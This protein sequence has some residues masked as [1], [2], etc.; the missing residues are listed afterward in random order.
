MGKEASG[1]FLKRRTKKLLLRCRAFAEMPGL[2]KVTKQKFFAS[3]FQKRRPLFLFLLLVATPAHAA[4]HLSVVLDWFINPDHAPIL[5]AQQIGAYAAEGLDVDLIQ[6]ADAT[7]GPKLVAAGQADLVLTAEPQFIEQVDAGLNLV[8]VG[9][10]ID[11][12]LSTLVVLQGSG[13]HKLAD[14][15]GKTIGYGA[16]EAERV[17]VGVMLRQAGLSLSN[18]HLVQIGEQLSVA[19]LSRQVDA[20]SVY[21]NFEPLEI[22]RQGAGVVQFDY[23]RN[24]VPVF[25][26]LMLAARPIIRNDTRFARFLR[27]TTR[28]LAYLH[29]HPNE[30]W[31]MVRR[32]HPD[33]DD[34]LNHAAWQATLPYFAT[35][36]GAAADYS[37]FARF[38]RDAGMRQEASSFLLK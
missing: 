37:G 17:M 10:L 14:L 9:V 22:A 16:S 23:E 19:L 11:R 34:P 24:G 31:E 21:R 26:D 12:P 20:V 3:F 36:A 5:V 2:S 35:N 18:V 25:E 32:S 13:I 28:G 33:I 27:A 38:L 29:A 30:S 7:L 15:R 8:R 1:S 6:P 4:D